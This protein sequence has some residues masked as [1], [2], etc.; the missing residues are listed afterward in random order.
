MLYRT[1]IMIGIFYVALGHVS[2]HAQCAGT[3]LDGTGL[4][5]FSGATVSFD[6]TPAGSEPESWMSGTSPDWHEFHD[7]LGP[8]TEIGGS[9]QPPKVVGNWEIIGNQICYTYDGP[10]ATTYCYYVYHLGGS[11]YRFCTSEDSG[12]KATGSID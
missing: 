9:L 8:L 11:V 1:I 10:P 5:I 3:L 6:S 7:P 12:E 4:G 2:A